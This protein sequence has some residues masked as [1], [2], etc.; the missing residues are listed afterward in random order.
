MKRGVY[1]YSRASRPRGNFPLA[2]HQLLQPFIIIT[3]QKMRQFN[4]QDTQPVEFYLSQTFRR[5]STRTTPP[6]RILSPTTN[7]V[8]IH[9]DR[10]AK[11]NLHYSPGFTQE[12]RKARKLYPYPGLP[13]QGGNSKN[14]TITQIYPA[15]GAKTKN[16]TLLP[17]IEESI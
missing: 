4:F 1:I 7:L 12:R 16:S 3:P 2:V 15:R 10:G 11:T 6:T 17:H 5:P 9:P 13:G 8:R 14:P